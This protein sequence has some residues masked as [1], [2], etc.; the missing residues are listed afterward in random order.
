MKTYRI[1]RKKIRKSHYYYKVQRNIFWIFWIDGDNDTFMS[2]SEAE[3]CIRNLILDK[4]PEP[5]TVVVKHYTS[6]DFV[7][8]K[9]KGLP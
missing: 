3:A 7:A 6:A 4:K 2:I 1:V 8:E 5:E 9:L